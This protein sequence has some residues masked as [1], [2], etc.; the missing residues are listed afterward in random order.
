LRVHAAWVLERVLEQCGS[1]GGEELGR[2]RVQLVGLGGEQRP[3]IV[4]QADVE[5][6]ELPVDERPVFGLLL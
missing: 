6:G 3:D 5:R 2:E 4:R 1:F